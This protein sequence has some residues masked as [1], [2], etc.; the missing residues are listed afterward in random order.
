MGNPIVLVV[1]A[2]MLVFAAQ[3]LFVSGGGIAVPARGSMIRRLNCRRFAV[4]PAWGLLKST[5]GA[6]SAA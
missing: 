2:T 1:G 5:P 6:I 4:P 3:A